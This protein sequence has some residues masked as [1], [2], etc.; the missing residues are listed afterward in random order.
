MQPA[1]LGALEDPIG[2]GDCWRDNNEKE[3]EGIVQ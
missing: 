2:E 1:V 3:V